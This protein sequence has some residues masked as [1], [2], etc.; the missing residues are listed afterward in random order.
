MFSCQ[1][2]DKIL[3]NCIE[4]V[5]RKYGGEVASSNR[6]REH[7]KHNGNRSSYEDNISARNEEQIVNRLFTKIKSNF[8]YH[9][10]VDTQNFKRDFV[11]TKLFI[12]EKSTESVPQRENDRGMVSTSCTYLTSLQRLGQSQYKPV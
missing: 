6:A 2:L 1:S 10:W 8:Q 12:V 4:F 11:C 9:T 7:K 3:P 5:E